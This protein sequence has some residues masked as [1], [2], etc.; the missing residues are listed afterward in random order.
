MQS[1]Q[2]F[3]TDDACGLI[4][5]AWGRC[6]RS[7][8]SCR[9]SPLF[10]PPEEGLAP[11]F[12]HL[13]LDFLIFRFWISPG[14]RSL[15]PMTGVWWGRE[16]PGRDNSQRVLSDG[17]DP[18]LG[19][20]WPLAR[21]GVGQACTPAPS[22]GWALPARG[23]GTAQ[24]CGFGKI[25]LFCCVPGGEPVASGVTCIQLGPWGSSPLALWLVRSHAHKVI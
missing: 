4:G 10:A 25:L 14:Q 17:S 24:P 20:R 5:D 16:A 22:S 19:F 18:G 9:S 1:F 7:T 21:Q 12:L 2:A 6:A 8:L 23:C 3:R 15:T 13:I 11:R